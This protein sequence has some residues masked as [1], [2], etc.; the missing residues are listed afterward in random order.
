[1]C[2]AIGSR[3]LRNF[4]RIF[5]CARF[6]EPLGIARTVV[7]ENRSNQVGRDPLRAVTAAERG[8]MVINTAGTKT[9]FADSV[10]SVDTWLP[11]AGVRDNTPK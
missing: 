8:G 5:E 3:R 11:C 10:A 1:M 7:M 9:R 6:V 4:H 2:G